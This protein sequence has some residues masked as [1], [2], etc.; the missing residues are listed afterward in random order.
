MK[1][2]LGFWKLPRYSKNIF[3]FLNMNPFPH[4]ESAFCC[5]VRNNE[6]EIFKLCTF[7]VLMDLYLLGPERLALSLLS[8]T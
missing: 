5:S 3:L 4:L 1:T 8:L 7:R 2:C 6:R